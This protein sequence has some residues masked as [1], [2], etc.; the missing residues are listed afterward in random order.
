MDSQWSD[1]K[2]LSGKD[3]ARLCGLSLLIAVCIGYGSLGMLF[4]PFWAYGWPGVSP[5][6]IIVVVAAF[7]LGAVM[8]FSAS[9]ILIVI[10]Y[11]V[12]RLIHKEYVAWGTFSVLM[13]ISLIAALAIC[14]LIIGAIAAHD[15]P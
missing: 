10:S 15:W 7:L 6:T 13:L 5:D 12:G 2:H 3:A 4:Q 1:Y 14:P 8:L 9:A 11:G